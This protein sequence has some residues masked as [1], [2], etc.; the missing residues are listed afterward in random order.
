[1]EVPSSLS[2]DNPLGSGRSS[3]TRTAPD[4]SV[5]YAD[6]GQ[7]AFRESRGLVPVGLFCNLLLGGTGKD[8]RSL[9]QIET[10]A[11]HPGETSS[12]PLPFLAGYE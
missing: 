2:E 1:M 4:G 5:G 10:L 11:A 12:K 7:L 8:S 3:A 9:A 6:N